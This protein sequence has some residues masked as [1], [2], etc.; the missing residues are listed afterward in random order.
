MLA[1]K[2][3]RITAQYDSL[4]TNWFEKNN[5]KVLNK[6]VLRYGENPNQNSF[7]ENNTNSIFKFQLS[8]KEISYNN[9]VDIDSGYKCLREFIEPTCIIVKHSNPCG[10]AS[11]ENINL[12]FKKAL[13]SDFKSSFGGIVLLN[14]NIDKNLANLISKNFFEV[15][16]A[17]N[18]DNQ[19]ISILQK[20]KKLI[21][22]KIKKIKIPKKE[23]KST[24]FGTIHQNVDF[25]NINTKFC[26]LVAY[27]KVSKNHLKIY[28]FL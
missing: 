24:I 14:R 22:L 23:Y 26:K 2:A 17:S 25:D 11:A 8:G 28:C 15:V 13:K 9:I 5:K 3:F 20:K 21:L 16:V 1:A 4:I 27:E 6:N 7:I 10:A 12:A 18:Y 19:A